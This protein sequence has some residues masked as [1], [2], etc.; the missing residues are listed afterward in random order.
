VSTNRPGVA[1]Q[2]GNHFASHRYPDTQGP[3]Q[4]HWYPKP[5]VWPPLALPCVLDRGIDLGHT[6]FN[7]YASVSFGE[8][9]AQLVV[10]C[11]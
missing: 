11:P 8:S 4:G 2:L 6:V 10:S 9:V 5:H 7:W 1:N 3:K